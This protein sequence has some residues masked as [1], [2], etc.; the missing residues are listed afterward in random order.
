[1][2]M[3]P[4]TINAGQI[5]IGK[6]AASSFGTFLDG[7]LGPCMMYDRALSQSE[8]LRNYNALKSRFGL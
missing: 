7:S 3:N 2:Q 4:G 5:N 6:G 8:I 1:M